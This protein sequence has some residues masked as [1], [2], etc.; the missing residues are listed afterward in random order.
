MD[1][2]LTATCA[3]TKE[4]DTG[5]VTAK[6]RSIIVQEPQRLCLVLCAVVA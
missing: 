2:S 5:R 4:S 3:L 6:G 1:T